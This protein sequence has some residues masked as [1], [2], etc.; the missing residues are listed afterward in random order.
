MEMIALLVAVLCQK[1]GS[2]R[3]LDNDESLP[4]QCTPLK[5]DR[6]AYEGLGLKKM[7]SVSY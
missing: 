7:S 4:K 3:E 6:E 1:L 2:E 5:T